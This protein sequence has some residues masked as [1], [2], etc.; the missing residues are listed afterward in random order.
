MKI[1]AIYD[2][3]AERFI[4]TSIAETDGVF[5]RQSLF[6]ILMDYAVNDFEIY[7]VG[8]FDADFGYIRPVVP[9]QVPLTAYKFPETRE[10]KDKYLTIEQIEKAAKEKREEL[11]KQK[12]ENIESLRQQKV[13]LNNLLDLEEGRE[14]KDKKK[15]KSLRSYINQIDD[16]INRL[17]E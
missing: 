5:I 16:E 14:K 10:S 11:N 4:S 3:V 15:I 2:K 6:A 1:Y 8:E 7:C 12:F 13:R 9:R 17:G